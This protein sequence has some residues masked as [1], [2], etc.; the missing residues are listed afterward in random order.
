M[1][2]KELEA[3]EPLEKVRTA[4]T[5]MVCSRLAAQE[6][7]Q[8]LKADKELNPKE[9]DIPIE[10]LEDVIEKCYTLEKNLGDAHH[11][12]LVSLVTEIGDCL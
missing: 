2:K 11:A 3:V 4:I 8:K 5:R 1:A 10:E 12:I 7:L 9:Y 6:A